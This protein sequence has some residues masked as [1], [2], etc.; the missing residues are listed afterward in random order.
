VKERYQVV[1][2]AQ[3]RAP[4]AVPLL[5]EV[6]RAVPWSEQVSVRRLEH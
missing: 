4:L 1:E 6:S 2:L 5:E 3:Q